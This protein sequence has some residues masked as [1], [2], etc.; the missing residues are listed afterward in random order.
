[1]NL[2]L[3]FTSFCISFFVGWSTTIYAVFPIVNP[4]PLIVLPNNDNQYSLINSVH[5]HPTQNIFCVTYTHN[6]KV[7]LYK[8][9][10]D[11]NPSII[12]T[13]CNPSACLKEPQ[14]A[15]FSPD[16]KKI[17]VANWR[18]RS[19][20]VY[21]KKENEL[22][23]DAP[24]TS[25]YL[26]NTLKRSKPHGIAFSPCGN[27]LVVACGAASFYENGI[28][29]FKSTGKHLIC[30]NYLTHAELPGIP[31]GICFTP[32]G[33]H[34]LVSF[35]EPCALSIY[36]VQNEKIKPVPEQIIRGIETG[37]SRPEDVKIAPDGTYCAVSNSTLNTVTFY[38]FNKDTNRIIDSTPI[39][40]LQNPEAQLTFPH[41][42]DFSFDG[43]YLAIT[44]FG[45]V[46]FNELGRVLWHPSLPSEEGTVNLYLLNQ[47]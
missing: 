27:Y 25:T 5:F 18:D 7:C 4:V 3:F 34:L 30:I 9:N 41:G 10:Q 31:K 45:S 11:S 28:A 12:Q 16:G 13:L 40:S 47:R 43:T 2:I 35:C 44:Q 33:T 21:L 22:F 19:L 24:S 23:S 39:Y 6:N 42:M 29:L 36:K 1:M 8:I 15:V 14:H 17:V 32:D 46:Y 20:N 37:L 38:L 26:P